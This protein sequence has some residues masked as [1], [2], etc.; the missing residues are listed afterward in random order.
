MVDDPNDHCSCSIWL[1]VGFRTGF[2]AGAFH[3]HA[4]LKIMFGNHSAVSLIQADSAYPKQ[5]PYHPNVKYPEYSIG[6]FS[7]EINLV[8]D[9]V[10]QSLL[11]LE[12]DKTNFGTKEWN[13]LGGLIKKG[14]TVFIKPNL[15]AQAVKYDP[16]IWEPAIT[17]G[18]VLRAVVD[19][20]YKAL[21]GEGRIFIGD[22][23]QTD[24][25]IGLILERTGITAIADFYKRKL[26]FDITFLD[27]R[28]EFWVDQE[29]IL[30]E[31]IKLQGDPE[32]T[33]RFNLGAKSYFAEFDHLKRT[34]YGAFY[35]IEETNKH[36]SNGLHEYLI[37]KTP[38]ECDVFINVPKLKTHKKVGMTLNLKSLVGI[39]GDKNWLPHYV[40]GSPE[41]LG[42]QFD[43]LHIREKLENK[44]VVAAK[45]ILLKRNKAIQ[46]VA[47]KTRKLAYK[48]FGDTEEVI[49]SGNW[50]GN[51]TCWRMALDL[52]KLL[53]YGKPDG[54]FRTDGSRKK[55]FSVVDGIVSMEGNGPAGGTAV[56]SG[57]ILA[58]SDPLNVD[59]TAAKII[60][61]DYRKLQLLQRA[62]DSNA[63]PIFTNSYAD[64][65]V[66]SNRPA[67]N[68]P[69]AA[70]NSTDC[71]HFKPHF[72]WKNKIEL[73]ADSS[74]EI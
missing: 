50:Y 73:S 9:M 62:Y 56:N 11:G 48:I 59:L 32:G 41:N 3:L 7:D 24:S 55:Y 74:K 6:E 25:D 22:G 43:K 52:N 63:L 19:Y 72:A 2:R 40:M 65:R 30:V 5:K 23:P 42:D 47:K 8:Y 29:G 66:V 69:L 38:I 15:M 21:D 67:F 10:R 26:N 60:G 16:N 61:L 71:Y 34:Y 33:A 53:L 46:F 13:P 54:Q 28:N 57:L 31:T 51:D 37:C 44:F 18:S 45:K 35:D 17:H 14:E 12:L 20:V 39:N 4:V 64:I 68:M 70:I 27:L 1:A 36:H 58:G 49:R